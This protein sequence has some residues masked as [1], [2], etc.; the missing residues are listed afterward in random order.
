M[1]FRYRLAVIK[2]VALSTLRKIKITSVE[3]YDKLM[4]WINYTVQVEN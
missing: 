4:D 1:I 3:L 2:D